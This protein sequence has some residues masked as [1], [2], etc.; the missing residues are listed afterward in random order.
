MLLPVCVH[1]PYYI[2]VT[3]RPITESN[4]KLLMDDTVGLK[5]LLFFSGYFKIQILV[6]KTRNFKT[7]MLKKNLCTVVR[8]MKLLVVLCETYVHVYV[9]NTKVEQGLLDCPGYY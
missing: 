8:K 2:S 3:I 5:L 4:Y 6:Y 7:V 9:P 1:V